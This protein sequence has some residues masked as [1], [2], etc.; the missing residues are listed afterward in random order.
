MF[1]YIYKT[2]HKPSGKIYIGKRRSKE[3]PIIDP[4]LGSGKHFKRALLKYGVEQFAKEIL[5]V[6][7]DYSTLNQREIHWIAFYNS[8]NPSIGYNIGKGGEF[9]DVM[10]HH[11]NKKQIYEKRAATREKNMARNLLLYGK[12]VPKA[13]GV[14]RERSV[15][16]LMFLKRPRPN[17]SLALKRKSKSI[18]H[19]ATMSLKWKENH[20]TLVCPKCNKIGTSPRLKH[21]HLESCGV[22][23]Q[24]MQQYPSGQQTLSTL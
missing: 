21:L 13:W 16:H 9:G 8:T 5:E 12:K 2:T 17:Q 24:I 20:P 14:K 3:E 23:M 7:V 11:P 6:C 19:K 18:E 1:H 4:Y 22:K 10:S 15:E